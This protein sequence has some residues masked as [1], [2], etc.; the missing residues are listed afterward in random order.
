MPGCT[1]RPA[2]SSP[3]SNCFVIGTVASGSLNIETIML[4]P[5][6]NGFSGIGLQLKGACL[7]TINIALIVSCNEGIELYADTTYG[8]CE[9]NTIN[10]QGI[11][12]STDGAIRV[13]TPNN[14]SVI[15]GN[16]IAVNFVNGFNSV[17]YFIAP[18]TTAAP[19]FNCNTFEFDAVDGDGVGAY[20]IRNG[21]GWSCTGDR[22]ICHGFFGGFAGSY[23][24]LAGTYDF[25]EFY[26]GGGLP[27]TSYS[28]FGAVEVV[29]GFGNRYDIT[30]GALSANLT[31]TAA[32]AAASRATFNSGNPVPYNRMVA[33]NF[34]LPASWAPSATADFYVYSPLVLGNARLCLNM[35]INGGCV[36]SVLSDHSG[37]NANEVH[38]QFTNTSGSTLISN[39]FVGTLVIGP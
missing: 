10:V 23:T 15:Q 37:V 33:I 26:F 11:Y 4:L 13:N 8:P 19:G 39:N 14:L 7:A 17:V 22:F 1:I 2:S 6:I 28:Q 3:A 9:N 27:L 38:V 25:N 20:Y 5:S 24:I 32:T 35:K 16:R 31:L 21:T 30:Y 29:P 36:T 12:A 34:P 18:G